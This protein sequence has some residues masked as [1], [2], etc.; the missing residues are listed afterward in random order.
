MN[1]I[2]GKEDKITNFLEGKLSARIKVAKRSTIRG[3]LRYPIIFRENSG[4]GFVFK[5]LW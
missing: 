3:S 2:N 5:V 1:F 4:F